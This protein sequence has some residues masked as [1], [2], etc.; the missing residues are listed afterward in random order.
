MIYSHAN[1]HIHRATHDNEYDLGRGRRMIDNKD[2]D[3]LSACQSKYACGNYFYL[4][5]TNVKDVEQRICAN[6]QHN[7][8]RK[9]KFYFSKSFS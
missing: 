5:I 9:N 1:F 6:G 3:I 7:N 8:N 4:E 2:K